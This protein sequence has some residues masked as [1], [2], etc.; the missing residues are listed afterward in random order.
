M[1]KTK[2]IADKISNLTDARYFSARC[3]D[4]ICYE[5]PDINDVAKGIFLINSIKEWVA[6]PEIFIRTNGLST[7]ELRNA[8]IE[9]VPVGLVVSFFDDY[10][11]SA[12]QGKMLIKEIIPEKDDYSK[13]TEINKSFDAIL[14]DVRNTELL[15]DKNFQSTLKQLST[16]YQIYIK[17]ND[18]EDLIKNISTKPYL[19]G[20]GINGGI[21]L[22]TGLKSFD[23][24]DAML[25]ELEC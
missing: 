25:D 8:V 15:G 11:L 2:I 24:V 3:C 14:V 19:S 23:Y 9:I 12:F 16:E 22:K 4:V 7:E 1:Y 10:D 13:L 5:I 17:S 21:E 6:G 20:I 18:F